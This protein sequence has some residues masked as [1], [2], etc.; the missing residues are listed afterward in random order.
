MEFN[1]DCARA[2]NCN[3]D[4]FAVLEGSY[5]KGIKPAFIPYVNEILDKMGYASSKVK[6]NIILPIGTRA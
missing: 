6:R 1:F 3:G 4:G 2:L 5:Q